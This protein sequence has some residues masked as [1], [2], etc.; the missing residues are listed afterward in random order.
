M[1]I[2]R[3]EAITELRAI[4]AEFARRVT[5]DVWLAGL[6]VGVPLTEAQRVQRARGIFRQPLGKSSS[7]L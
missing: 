3:E 1:T 4:E 7:R 5:A 2:T 6:P